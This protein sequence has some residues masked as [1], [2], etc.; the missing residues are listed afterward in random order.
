MVR[1]EQRRGPWLWD[2]LF[3]P[4]HSLGKEETESEIDLLGMQIS[5]ENQAVV[6]GGVLFEVQ[7]DEELHKFAS[8]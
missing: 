2:L 6:F 7:L 5:T 4:A 3:L 1:T 8:G